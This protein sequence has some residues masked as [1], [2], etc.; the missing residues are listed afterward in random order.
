MDEVR[1]VNERNFQY[2]PKVAKFNKAKDLVL[3]LAPDFKGPALSLWD[4]GWDGHIP[5][6]MELVA[7]GYPGYYGL[8][9]IFEH[10]FIKDIVNFEGVE[11]VVSEEA[12]YSGESGGPVLSTANG[13]VIGMVDA[14]IELINWRRFPM[15]EHVSI[16]LFVSAMEIRAFLAK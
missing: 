2:F 16:S 11:M 3:L 5:R 7:L 15:H 1:M 9:F 10:G 4:G 14:G 6:G 8:D 13:K 12:S